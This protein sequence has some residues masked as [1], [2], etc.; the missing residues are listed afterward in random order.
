[1]KSKCGGERKSEQEVLGLVGGERGEGISRKKGAR[2]E[3]G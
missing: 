3:R 1:M 2:R